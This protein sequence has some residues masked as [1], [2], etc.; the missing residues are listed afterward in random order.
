[1]AAIVGLP[2]SSANAQRE[3]APAGRPGRAGPGGG[4]GACR[5][6]RRGRPWQASRHRENRV[7]GRAVD[8]CPPN[9]SRLLPL[10]WV[11]H[12]LGCRCEDGERLE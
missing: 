1:M 8:T 11:H 9:F 12:R 2:M 4:G 5:S 7:R 10:P 3:G 6:Q